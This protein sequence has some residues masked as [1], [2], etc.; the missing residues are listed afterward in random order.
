M[1]T[2][3]VEKKKNNKYQKISKQKFQPEQKCLCTKVTLYAKV[4]LSMFDTLALCTIKKIEKQNPNL[5]LL[6]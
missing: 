4:F 3:V 2:Q 6:S 1:V 5:T